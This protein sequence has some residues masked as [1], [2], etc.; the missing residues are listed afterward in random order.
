MREKILALSL[1][2][3]DNAIRVNLLGNNSA[4]FLEQL[5]SGSFT[6]EN[7][8]NQ[9]QLFS[10]DTLFDESKLGL[11]TEKAIDI[12]ERSEKLGIK[13]I[14]LLDDDYP[15]NLRSMPDCPLILFVKG[16]MNGNYEKAIGCVGTRKPSKYGIRAVRSL[17][18]EWT[19]NDFVIV[20]GLAEGI[21]TASHKTC[22]ENDGVTIAVLAH[23][24]DTIY[25]KENIELAE[26]II[27]ENGILLSEYPIGIKPEKY[28]FVKRNRLISGLSKALVVFETNINSGTM[29]TVKYAKEQNKPI[30]CPAPI[31]RELEQSKGLIKLLEDKTAIAI[32]SRSYF[33]ILIQKLG[34]VLDPKVQQELNYDKM[35]K[36]IIHSFSATFTKKTNHETFEE[37][38]KVTISIDAKLYEKINFLAQNYGYTTQ[39]FFNGLELKELPMKNHDLGGSN[40]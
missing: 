22:I 13:T 15:I 5:G 34:Y 24:L 36:D 8:N 37:N 2:G 30:F 11:Y 23:G 39:D 4:S 33:D 6:W 19:K 27:E 1:M 3:L 18:A 26:K 29:H 31:D 40:E 38:A 16:S 21:D 28:N 35:F 7:L 12:I 32:Q 9:G 25:P 20:S 14:S 17:V 10:A